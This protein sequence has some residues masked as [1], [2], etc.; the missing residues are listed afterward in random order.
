VTDQHVNADLTLWR[1]GVVSD[2]AEWRQCRRRYSSVRPYCSRSPTQSVAT[3]VTRQPLCRWTLL[4]LGPAPSYNVDTGEA[5][6]LNPA[7]GSSLPS[8]SQARLNRGGTASHTVQADWS[9]IGAGTSEGPHAPAANWCSRWNSAPFGRLSMF[10][11]YFLW[12][13]RTVCA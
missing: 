6:P 9:S 8:Y 2:C 12:P 3:W 1:C 7:N 4:V 11:F 10:I 5:A 13:Q